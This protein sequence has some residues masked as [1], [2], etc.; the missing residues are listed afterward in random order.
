MISSYQEMKTYLKVEK[1]KL[2]VKHFW[3][4]FLTGSE[5]A[6]IYYYMWVLRHLEL[7]EYKKKKY[8]PI[9]YIFLIW[10]RFLRIKYNIHLG[11]G[12]AGKGFHIVHLGYIRC[13]GIAKIGNNCTVLPMVLFG[14]K[15][16][17]VPNGYQIFVGDNC[18]IGTGSTILAPCKIGHNVTIAAGSVVIDDIPDNCIVAGVPAKIKKYKINI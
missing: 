16:P 2:K 18:Y 15:D 8:L 1:S 5:F 14:K 10:H 17:S 4:Q 13:Y 3:L 9:F 12:V 11:P 6:R 7:L